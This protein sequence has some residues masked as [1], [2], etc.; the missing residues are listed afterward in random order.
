MAP[1]RVDI[2]AAAM[3]SDLRA[4]SN[5]RQSSSVL[6]INLQPFHTLHLQLVIGF[7]SPISNKKPV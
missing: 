5:H 1:Q 3:H 2:D 4:I 6:I 7:M